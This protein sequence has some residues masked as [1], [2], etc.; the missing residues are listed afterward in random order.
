MGCYEA[1]T[2][3]FAQDCTRPTK[4]GL[5]SKGLILNVEDIDHWAVS[6]AANQFLPVLKAGKVAFPIEVLGSNPFTGTNV[7]SAND[8]FQRSFTKTVVFNIPVSG[9]A[10]ALKVEQLT[11]SQ[12][13]FVIMVEGKDAGGDLNGT[14]MI[15]GKDEPL[16]CTVAK[17]YV[18][19]VSAPII[20]AT[21]VE[22]GYENFFFMTDLATTKTAFD[23]LY[24]ADL[25]K[26]LYFLEIESTATAT[27]VY[28]T[29]IFGTPPAT[30]LYNLLCMTVFAS[31]AVGAPGA[32]VD[33]PTVAHLSGTRQVVEEL[34][35]MD[36]YDAYAIHAVLVEIAPE[37][38]GAPIYFTASMYGL[39]GSIT[40]IA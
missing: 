30:E 26:R 29:L 8:E 37:V 28:A 24:D 27:T 39:I 11:K 15:F 35:S 14:F 3:G 1:L 12:W 5:R 34:P 2:G 19:G 13:G 25:T 17:D 32:T 22:K 38:A 23:I 6:G 36:D 9:S 18:A 21:S 4:S 10:A 7:A 20:T 31:G 40:S 16:L 33:T